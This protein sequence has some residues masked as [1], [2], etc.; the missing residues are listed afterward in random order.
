MSLLNDRIGL[1]ID[2]DHPLPWYPPIC[3]KHPLKLLPY[4][5]VIS[6]FSFSICFFSLTKF[7]LGMSRWRRS[8]RATITRSG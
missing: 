8:K 1:R 2:E 5:E 6:P 4:D 3:E 7:G